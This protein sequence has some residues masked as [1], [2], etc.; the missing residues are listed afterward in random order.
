MSMD[1]CIHR[2]AIIISMKNKKI[3]IGVAGI[4]VIANLIYAYFFF[5]ST[6]EVIPEKVVS[7]AYLPVANLTEGPMVTFNFDDGYRS[8]FAVGMPILESAGFKTTHYIVHNRIAQWGYMDHAEILQL[9]SNGHEIGAHSLTHSILTELPL[10]EARKEIVGSMEELHNMGIVKV[11]SFSY[12]DGYFSDA[13]ANLVKEAG[14]TSARI[15]NPGLNDK[16]TDPYT[17][18]YLGMNAETSFD[19]VKQKI[20]EAIEKKKWLIMVFHKVD[21]SGYENVTSDFLQKT[22]DYIKENQVPVVTT[23]QG[24]YVLG[25]IPQ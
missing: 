9:Q 18:L 25:N 14:Y 10:E 15:T 3:V 21:E 17:L 2:F 16:T 8:A 19:T 20:D 6:P 1:Y 4:L 7:A 11:S 24:L 5:G 13:I 23:T 22:V 12:P